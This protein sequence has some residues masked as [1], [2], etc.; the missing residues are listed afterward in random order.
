MA[1]L[2][3]EI[4]DLIGVPKPLAANAMTSESFV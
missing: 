2:L 1:R 4:A 3:Q